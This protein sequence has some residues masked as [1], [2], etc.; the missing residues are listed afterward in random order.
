MPVWAVGAVLGLDGSAVNICKIVN[1]S[2]ACARQVLDGRS[3]MLLPASSSAF[4]GLPGCPRL[5]SGCGGGA[6]RWLGC[7][8]AYCREGLV[9]SPALPLSGSETLGLSVLLSELQFLA[10]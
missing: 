3:S 7:S 8:G 5:F 4:W 6:R 10:A 2:L 1:L 9:P